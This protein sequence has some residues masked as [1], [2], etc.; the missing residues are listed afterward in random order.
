MK[1]LLRE[2]GQWKP[3][4]KIEFTI[5]KYNYHDLRRIIG[6]AKKVGATHVIV[7]NIIPLTLEHEEELA[8][9]SDE[10][11]LKEIDRL[12]EILG[13]ESLDSNVQVHFPSFNIV[14]ERQCPFTRNYALYTRWDG[15]ITPCIYYAHTWKNVFMGIERRIDAVILEDI[16]QEELIDIWRRREDATFRLRATIFNQPSCLDCPLQQ[17]CTLTETNQIDC[18]SNTP[19]CAHY[20]YSHDIVRCLL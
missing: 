6:Y 3:V 12:K 10:K 15:L 11:C 18:W 1:E 17:Y 7:S 5:N 4:I 19:T 14:I 20:P 13:K 16:N 9:Y 2:T 8:C